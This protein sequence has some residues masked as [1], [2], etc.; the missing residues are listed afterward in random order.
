MLRWV[1]LR[2]GEAR[3]AACALR[4]TLAGRLLLVALGHCVNTVPDTPALWQP[5][6]EPAL[7]R[8]TARLGLR[9]GALGLNAEPEGIW[10]S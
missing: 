1:R 10:H 7:A 8:S 5:R 2:V 6:M 3:G 9:V 4:L